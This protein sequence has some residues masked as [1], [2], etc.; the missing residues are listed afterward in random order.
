MALSIVRDSNSIF[1][2]LSKLGEMQT[3]QNSGAKI[4]ASGY[5]RNYKKGNTAM[6]TEMDSSLGDTTLMECDWHPT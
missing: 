3:K 5:H 1:K 4:L 2:L 6:L